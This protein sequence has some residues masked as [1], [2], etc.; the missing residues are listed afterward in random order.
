MAIWEKL[1]PG[2]SFRSILKPSSLSELSVQ[3]RVSWAAVAARGQAREARS[4][5]A[6]R[7]ARR[8]S[9]CLH[10]RLI[11]PLPG[12]RARSTSPRRDCLRPATLLP[13]PELS[14][15]RPV[16]LRPTLSGGLPLAGPHCLHQTD[17]LG[18][19]APDRA[20]A[21][22][23]RLTERGSTFTTGCNRSASG[24]RLHRRGKRYPKRFAN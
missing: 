14:G 7:R 24:P 4:R 3:V 15:V 5:A 9:E 16:V 18:Y 17:V 10:R 1:P 13:Y 21:R 11:A 12:G 6:V 22:H 20:V 2:P 23:G 19:Q 8:A